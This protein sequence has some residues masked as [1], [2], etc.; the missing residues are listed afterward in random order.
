VE[1]IEGE[2]IAMPPMMNPHAVGL[3]LAQD[4]LGAVFGTDYWV[5]NQLPLHFGPRSEPEPDVAVVPG[6][7]RDYQDHPTTALLVV[8]ISDTSLRY[9]RGRK[10]GVY[11]RAGIADY[12]IV[13]LVDNQL[14]AFRDPQPDSQQPG[15]Y[16]YGTITVLKATEVLAPLAA[17]NARIAVNDLLP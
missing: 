15:R 14:E 11:A 13:N 12:W 16:A 8:E 1:L 17:A 5:R 9:D 3:G 7:P 6:E 10:A 2:I 4:V